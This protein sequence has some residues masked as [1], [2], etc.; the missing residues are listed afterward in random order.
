MSMTTQQW[1]GIRTAASA[2]LVRKTDETKAEQ[3]VA[4][5]AAEHQRLIGYQLAE[6][7]QQDRVRLH[8]EWVESTRREARRLAN[9]KECG[10]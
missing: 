8:D 6:A 10:K 7:D 9:C 4:E 3:T 2:I 1:Y 5:R